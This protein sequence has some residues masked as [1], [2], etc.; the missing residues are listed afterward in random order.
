VQLRSHDHPLLPATELHMSFASLPSERARVALH[1]TQPTQSSSTMPTTYS[2]EEILLL[3]QAF[4]DALTVM[5]RERLD[6]PTASLARRIFEAAGT[7]ERDRYALG[8]A[9]L[10]A[11]ADLA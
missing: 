1:A 2:A 3:R 11:F 4:D 5:M 7:G 8:R 9:A 10:G 6:I